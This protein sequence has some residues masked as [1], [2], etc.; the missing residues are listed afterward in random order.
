M[1]KRTKPKKKK[2]P[3][4]KPQIE[5]DLE[6][7]KAPEEEIPEEPQHHEFLQPTS[8][9]ITPVLERTQPPQ[10]IELEDLTSTIQG[11]ETDEERDQTQY[12]STPMTEEEY[13]TAQE[14]ER[15]ETG[16]PPI[17][18]IRNFNTESFSSPTPRTL[19]E[20]PEIRRAMESEREDKYSP[21]QIANFEAEGPKLPF[22]QTR[23]Y[24]GR[25]F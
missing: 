9:A 22:E 17:P 7:I 13:R 24:K 6:K 10:P 14:E 15:R 18:Q 21:E 3:K 20:N 23:K 2:A 12:T 1:P 11:R 25:S 8:R 5:I 4:K 19:H 16:G